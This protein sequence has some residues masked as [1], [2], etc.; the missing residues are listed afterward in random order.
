MTQKDWPGEECLYPMISDNTIGDF[1]RN[2]IASRSGNAQAPFK[3]HLETRAT[4]LQVWEQVSGSGAQP[5]SCSRV[6]IPTP[7]GLLPFPE[8]VQLC[9]SGWAQESIL[10]MS[11]QSSES[12]SRGA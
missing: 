10:F 6:I 9:S 3:T 12:G 7:L 8:T 4:S 1:L 11:S 5:G 2:N